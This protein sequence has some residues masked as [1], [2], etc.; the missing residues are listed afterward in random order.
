MRSGRLRRA[1][2]SARCSARVSPCQEHWPGEEPAWK[3][4]TSTQCSFDLWE[5]PLTPMA[6]TPEAETEP[7]KTIPGSEPESC[8][9]GPCT[10]DRPLWGWLILREAENVF[11]PDL[12]LSGE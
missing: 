6:P 10:R 12:L 8:A 5:H 11:C 3:L 2:A 9:C 1:V 4:A 7:K